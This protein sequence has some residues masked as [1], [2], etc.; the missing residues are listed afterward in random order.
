[1]ANVKV[2]NKNVHD[3]KAQFRDQMISI[4]AKSFIEM[5]EGEAQDFKYDFSPVVKGGDNQPDPKFFKMIEIE[6]ITPAASVKVEENVCMM[7]KH[8][9]AS[10]SDLEKHTK[11]FHLDQLEDQNLADDIKKGKK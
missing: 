5:E 7:C 6:R 10:K 11:E 1:M 2:W 8:K 9:A 3:F 4:P